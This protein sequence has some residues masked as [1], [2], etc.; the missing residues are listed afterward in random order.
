MWLSLAAG[1]G[2]EPGKRDRDALA[3]SMTPEQI[4]AAQKLASQWKPAK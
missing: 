1:Q 4:A 2:Y 3:A